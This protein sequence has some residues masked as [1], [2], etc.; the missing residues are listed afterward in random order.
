MAPSGRRPRRISADDLADYGMVA[1]RSVDV[2]KAARGLGVSKRV[3]KQVLSEAQGTQSNMFFQ[4]LSGRVEADTSGK[5]GVRGMLQ[6]AFGKGPR[7]GAVD[8][9]AAAK[10]LGVSPNTVRRWTAGTQK[11]SPE[12]L[13]AVQGASRRA[14]S[15]QRGRRGATTDFR[16]S[17]QGKR[18]LRVGGT[19][20]IS[21]MQGPEGDE[22]YKRDRRITK[23]I[24]AEQLEAMF[25]AY[26][27]GGDRALHDWMLDFTQGYVSG[28]EF[29]SIDEIEF[30]DR[31]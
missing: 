8:A 7:G 9:R 1:G 4:K 30:G 12:H 15:T 6:A 26:E 2:E 13:K 24:S 5:G 14:A 16:S 27:R 28:W 20:S 10:E 11:P 18:A 29:Q 25:D 3:V 17:A 23:E 22:L 19:L 31:S 21:G